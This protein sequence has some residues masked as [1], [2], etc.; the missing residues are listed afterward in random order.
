[1]EE[2]RV[3]ILRSSSSL[4]D[5]EFDSIR[6]K[7]EKEM[8][9][10]E[11]EMERFRTQLMAKAKEPHSIELKGDDNNNNNNNRSTVLQ[12]KDPLSTVRTTST[13][14]TSTK[15]LSTVTSSLT[16]S[17][18]S[19]MSRS[20]VSSNKSMFGRDHLLAAD[21]GSSQRQKHMGEEEE[22][23]VASFLDS[24]LIIS[25]P[26][27]KPTEGLTVGASGPTDGRSEETTEVERTGTS[28]KLLRLRFDV[29]AFR[30]EE[31]LVTTIGRRLRVEAHS[32][33]AEANVRSSRDYCREFLLPECAP[34]EQIESTLSAD[35]ILTIEAP[36]DGV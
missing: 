27:L 7:F 25:S 21:G 34:L 35:G 36:L 1:M 8:K 30:P 11:S 19:A 14:T 17:S 20:V 16:S 31:V 26:A 10:M 12:S 15:S 29:S 5:S 9:K 6:N 2:K 13:K 4:I 32:E 24:P 18:S 3:P 33:L 23:I 22:A 28:D